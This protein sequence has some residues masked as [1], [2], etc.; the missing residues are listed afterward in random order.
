M[1]TNDSDTS[2]K[3]AMLNRT[4]RTGTRPTTMVT[5]SDAE[6]LLVW[7]I[8]ALLAAPKGQAKPAGRIPLN[9]TASSA[10]FSA[11]GSKVAVTTDADTVKI[12]DVGGRKVITTSPILPD[13]PEI[14]D[15]VAV[16]FAG[17][18]RVVVASTTGS[19]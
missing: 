14:D 1:N 2:T 16:V 9:A 15:V 5:S 10:A 6:A 4:K 8:D 17:D 7:D 12:C 19:E 3:G 11:D 18:N 13:E